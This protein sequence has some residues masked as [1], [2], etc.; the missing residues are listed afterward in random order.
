MI[1][2]SMIGGAVTGALSMVFAVESLAPHGGV[3]VLFAISP[4]WGFLAAIAA[5]T[6]VTA[7]VVVALKTWVGNRSTEAG[8]STGQPAT[9]AV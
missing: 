7:V 5:G 2:A 6:I 8:A 4:A 3:F 9:A 1:P